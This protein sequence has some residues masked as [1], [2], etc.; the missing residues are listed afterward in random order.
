MPPEEE[1]NRDPLGASSFEEEVHNAKRYNTM[2][3][4]DPYEHLERRSIYRRKSF[5]MEFVDKK[6]PP[7]ILI[8][9]VLLA[10]GFGSTV[11]VVPA[12]MSDRYARLNH[13]YDDPTECA[14]WSIEDKPHECLLGSADAQNAAAY[15]SLV[16][17]MFTF[18]TS[19]M[20]GSISDEIGRKG[21]L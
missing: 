12:V 8:L 11:G 20:I 10:L 5:L 15:E 2:T 7:Q 1:A 19:S 17:N 13:G 6:G 9:C 21:G 18:I 4:I 3:A 16:S 14:K